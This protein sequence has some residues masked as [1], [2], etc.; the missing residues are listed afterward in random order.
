LRAEPLSIS[1]VRRESHLKLTKQS[2][3]ASR[4]LAEPV[5]PRNKRDLLCNLFP[6]RGDVPLGSIQ[7]IQYQ[8]RVH[9]GER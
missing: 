9:G 6:I 1:D 3:S 2:L 7:M 4:V 8:I 5:K